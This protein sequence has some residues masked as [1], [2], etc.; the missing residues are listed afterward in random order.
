MIRACHRWCVS[1]NEGSFAGP[2]E[3]QRLVSHFRPNAFSSRGPLASAV[4]PGTRLFGS[5]LRLSVAVVFTRR[6]CL[7]WSGPIEIS[8][9]SFSIGNG[10][11]MALKRLMAL[12]GGGVI[13]LGASAAMVVAPGPWQGLL[14]S[15]MEAGISP[16]I[17]SLGIADSGL[18]TAPLFVAYTL[19]PLNNTLFPGNFRA[20][21]GL[22]PTAVAYDSGKGELFFAT[23]SAPSYPGTGNVEVL[24]DATNT[25]VATIPFYYGAGYMVYDS[26]KGEVFVASGGANIVSVIS[27]ATNTVVATIPVG[28]APNYMVYD[29]GKGEVFVAN[30]GSDSIDVIS[31]ATNAVVATIPVGFEPGGVAYDQGQREVFVVNPPS[32]S[33]SVIS[34]ATNAVV[35]TIQLGL[36]PAGVV[37]DSGKGEVFVANSGSSTVSVISDATNMVDVT[38]P[39]GGSPFLAG[40]A[41]DRERGEVFVANTG[42]NS[43]SVI[44]D[45]TNTV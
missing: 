10:E 29:N 43:V 36:S 26:G 18:N 40:L 5:I 3:A 44:S 39:V 17:R 34:D 28:V 13:V 21:N 42:S 11:S 15:W 25:V 16:P 4:A 27:D 33:V 41:Y 14:G 9:A 37:Y 19:V 20:S 12:L 45:S 31:D 23:Y 22:G 7:S 8:H 35:T 30:S 32:D 24:S 1:V 38:I 2:R 6:I